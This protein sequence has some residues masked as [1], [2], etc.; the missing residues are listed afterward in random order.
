M[1]EEV[2]VVVVQLS[3]FISP[4]NFKVFLL[5]SRARSS[6]S[7]S[8]ATLSEWI[9]LVL[10]TGSGCQQG[11]KPLYIIYFF[12][13]LAI[14]LIWF[15]CSIGSFIWILKEPPLLKSALKKSDVD[16]SDSCRALHPVQ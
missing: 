8:L 11:P 9:H 13:S 12:T 15:K 5:G 1:S 3:T 4:P 10:L 7:L 2:T 14:P 6:V 16:Q